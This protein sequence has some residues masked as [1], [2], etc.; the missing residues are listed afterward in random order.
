MDD[1]EL[2]K[3]LVKE[4]QAFELSDPLFQAS[5]LESLQLAEKLHGVKGNEGG[6]VSWQAHWLKG[7]L[8]ILKDED[9]D[10]SFEQR[11]NSILQSIRGKRIK[12]A[13]DDEYLTLNTFADFLERF[14]VTHMIKIY[15]ASRKR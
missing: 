8:V 11:V 10:M 13:P 3:E 5:I 4:L 12:Q 2:K 14:A 1:S 6:K 9:A 7:E 15:R